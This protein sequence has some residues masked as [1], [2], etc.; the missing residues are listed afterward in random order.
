MYCNV[1]KLYNYVINNDYVIIKFLTY[2]SLLF[3]SFDVK[4]RIKSVGEDY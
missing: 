3:H 1:C 2:K 4:R